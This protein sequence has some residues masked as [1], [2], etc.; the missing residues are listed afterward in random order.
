MSAFILYADT[1]LTPHELIHHACVLCRDGLISAVGGRSAFSGLDEVPFICRPGCTIIPGLIDTHLHGGGAFDLLS[2]DEQPEIGNAVSR[3]LAEHGVTSFL[4]SIQGLTGERTL[5]LAARLASLCEAGDG[6]PGAVSA[7]IHF[8]GPFLNNSPDARGDIPLES[9]APV[10]LGRARDLLAAARGHTRI[11]TFAPELE[12][13]DLLLALLRENRVVPSMG[14]TMAD[15]IAAMRAIEAG[16]TRC[17]HFFNGMPPL[18]QR[19]ISLTAVAITDDR[20]TIELI[21]DGIHVHPRMIRLACRAKPNPQVVLVSDAIVGASLEAGRFIYGTRE[22]EV[23]GQRAVDTA[24]GRLAGSCVCL[25]AA[26]RNFLAINPF[27]SRQEAFACATANAAESIGLHDRGRIQPGRRADLTVLDAQDQVV[28]TV[29]GGRI[30]YD[31]ETPS[32]AIP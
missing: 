16:A 17:A 5:A 13:S 4:P 23:D 29:V 7:G 6:L 27:L 18:R 25:D 19:D 26:L 31:R 14:H 9:L 30:V 24:T 8:E 1:C 10:D 11:V 2:L 22:V 28:M 12:R 15:E 21:A 3:F 20:V 32:V